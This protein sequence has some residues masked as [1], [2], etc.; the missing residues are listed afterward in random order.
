MRVA[1][2][3]ASI[4]PRNGEGDHAEHGGGGPR[5]LQTPIK[6]V[7]RARKLRRQMSL[8]EVL[9]WQ[10]LRKRP[11]GLKF[12]RQFP[13]SKI[14]TDSACLERRLVIEIDGEG[15]SLGDQPRRDAVR[16]A[17]LEREGFRVYGEEL[18]FVFTEIRKKGCRELIIDGKRVDISA[19]VPGDAA[20]DEANV[21]DM[22]AVVRF[23]LASCSDV[24]PL[25][26]LAA[27]SPPRSGEEL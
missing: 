5:V 24:G 3:A 14:T 26:Q 18:D 25:H 1:E 2:R 16:D 8:P 17:L 6:Q 12:R 27:G 22:D 4:P 9:L 23:I 10:V 11:A 13:I 21:K 19:H 15:H 7:K 20:L